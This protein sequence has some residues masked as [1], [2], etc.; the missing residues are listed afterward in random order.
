MGPN[1]DEFP[2][3]DWKAE[4]ESDY[5]QRAVVE[6]LR[7]LNIK[8]Y[9]G[10]MAREARILGEDYISFLS[11]HKT[12]PDFPVLMTA[13]KIPYAHKW[14]LY[15]M[16]RKGFTKSPVWKQYLD[17]QANNP[18]T[19]NMAMIYTL[20]GTRYAV[21]HNYTGGEPLDPAIQLL[22]QNKRYWIEP[23]KSLLARVKWTR[24]EQ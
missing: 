19:D 16:W 4:K 23:L 20:P 7:L 1:I 8:G 3:F 12:F 15:E 24:P 11:F 5:E 22:V 21:L 17:I 2:D 6:T 14:D 9:N 13:K 18:D 10:L